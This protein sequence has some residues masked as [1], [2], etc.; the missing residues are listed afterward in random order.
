MNLTDKYNNIITIG[1]N[2]VDAIKIKSGYDWDVDII[3][4]KI[5]I[6]EKTE[7]DLTAFEVKLEDNTASLADIREYILKKLI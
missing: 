4:G 5:V 2:D 6:G 3:T 7:F 1:D